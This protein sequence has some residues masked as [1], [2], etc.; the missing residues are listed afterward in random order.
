[1]TEDE[2]RQWLAREG[3]DTV[4]MVEREP[5]GMLDTHSHPFEARALVMAGEITIEAE[6]H[7]RRY[8]P[9]DVFQ[10]GAHIPHI[11]RYGPQGVRYLAGRK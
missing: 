7:T 1:M 4:V 8:G 11:E 6:G 5:D 10:L 3:V 9:G 2:F